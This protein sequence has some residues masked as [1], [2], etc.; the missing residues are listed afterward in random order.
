MVEAAFTQAA[1][2]LPAA[3]L[4]VVDFAAA[5]AAALDRGSPLAWLPAL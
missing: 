2:T 1:P 5:A 4:E 3:G